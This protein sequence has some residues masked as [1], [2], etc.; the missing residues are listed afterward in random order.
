MEDVSY[1]R[2]DDLAALDAVGIDRKAV[3]RK[4]YNVYL[5]QFFVTYRVHADPHPGNLFI[6]PLPIS[7]EIASH[8]PNWGGYRPGDDVPYAAGRPFEIVIVDF[9]MFVELPL[10][11]REALREFAIG[12]GTRDARRILE[13]YAKVGVVQPGANMGRLEEMI[14]NQLDEL[15]GSFLGQV[16]KSDLT[17]PAAK[18]FFDKYEGLL[19]HTLPVPNRD[20]LCDARHGPSLRRHDKPRP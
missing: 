11:L 6:R 2:I 14:Q 13:S 18:A 15:W 8:S 20:A 3:A 16:R 5:E 4:V 7:Q 10:R 9:G 1:F 19:R 17:G 12:L